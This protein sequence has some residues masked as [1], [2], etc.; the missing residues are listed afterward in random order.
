MKITRFHCLI[1]NLGHVLF[2]RNMPQI[3]FFCLFIDENTECALKLL[4]FVINSAMI[5][6]NEGEN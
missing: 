2:R 5:L 6:Q 3:D 4:H 1:F